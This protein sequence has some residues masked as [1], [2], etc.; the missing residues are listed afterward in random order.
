MVEVEVEVDESGAVVVTGAEP[1]GA[2]VV[3]AAVGADDAQAA[4]RTAM[5]ASTSESDAFEDATK[6]RARAVWLTT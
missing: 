4:S 5:E 2:F 1:P 6:R 3:G